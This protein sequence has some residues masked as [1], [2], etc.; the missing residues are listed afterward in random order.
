MQQVHPATGCVHLLAE[1]Q[2]RFLQHTRGHDIGLEQRRRMHVRGRLALLDIER[3]RHAVVGHDFAQRVATR[4]LHRALAHFCLL[5]RVAVAIDD[6]AGRLLR[7]LVAHDVHA[8]H[9][10][11]PAHAV[12]FVEEILGRHGREAEVFPPRHLLFAAMPVEQIREQPAR[13]VRV[14][15]IM[16]LGR[17]R[18]E[19]TRTRRNL[20]RFERAHVGRRLGGLDLRPRHLRARGDDLRAQ[21]FE[22]VAERLGGAAVVLVV[23]GHG[24]ARL[25]R[26]LR[27]RA[28]FEREF[29]GGQVH[30]RIGQGHIP[31]E[32]VVL[33]ELLDRIALHARADGLPHH[34]QQVHEAFAAQ[35]PVELIRPR[36]VAAHE[37]LERRGLVGRVVIH[38]H[39]GMRGPLRGNEI[40]YL[41]E[42]ALLFGVVVRPP[43]AVLALHPQAEEIFASALARVGGSFQIEEQ[44]AGGW[45]RQ[46]A[47]PLR[48]HHRQQLVHGLARGALLMLHA[49]LIAQPLVGLARPTRGCERQRIRQRCRGGKRGHLPRHEFRAM[50]TADAGDE[51]QVVVRPATSIAARPP[52][53]QLA[54]LDRLGI[55]AREHRLVPVGQCREQPA[56]HTPVVRRVVVHA[57]AVHDERHRGV[58]RART[59]RRVGQCPF[60]GR[61]A[62]R[63]PHRRHHVEALRRHTL[64]PR[65]QLG[66]RRELQDGATARLSR[67]LRVVRLVAPRAEGTRT[68]HAHEHVRVTTPAVAAKRCLVD[69]VHPA[70]HRRAR[71]LV[72]L[73]E[74]QVRQIRHLQRAAPEPPQVA[75][76]VLEPAIAQRLPYRIAPFG[77]RECATR[78]RKVEPG[79]VAAGEE[80]REVRGREDE[81]VRVCGVHDGFPIIG[82]IQCRPWLV[83]PK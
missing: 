63:F 82:H 32:A 58:S 4:P 33:L 34:G 20:P 30:A 51:R 27:R 18:V 54:R 40:H 23:A 5:Q 69:H 26:H 65:Q 9:E 47:Q 11:E 14:P 21:A 8:L 46:P 50:R 43:G 37:P 17:Q 28:A 80:G 29:E 74:R 66:I 41:L 44:I 81:L 55:R 79:L 15:G 62:C 57:V 56:A 61:R 49:C 83:T 1:P 12:L 76:L 60:A 67:E 13:V 7:L 16:C 77:F 22:P 31:H 36:R 6:R 64:H 72:R 2:Q 48:R 75:P 35:Q 38:V 59:R 42:R 24:L 68:L 45:L 70:R 19:Q 39:A 53:A 10:L 25:V 73:L 52:A 78:H 71:P 3:A